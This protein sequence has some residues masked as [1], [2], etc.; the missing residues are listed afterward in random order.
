M[1]KEN[2]KVVVFK[3]CKARGI[4]RWVICRVKGV[5]PLG[6]DYGHTVKVILLALN[7]LKGGQRFSF[8]ARHMNRLDDVIINLNDGNPTHT[9]QVIIR[10]DDNDSP[11]ENPPHNP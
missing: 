11:Q 3:G 6:A 5:K 1:L 8:Y 2:D 10:E 7:G 4:A 9:I